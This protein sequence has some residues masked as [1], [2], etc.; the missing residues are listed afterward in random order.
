MPRPN[1]WMNE[2]Y[3]NIKEDNRPYMD[4]YLKDMIKKSFIIFERMKRGQRKVYF[5]GNW[6]K[7]VCSCFP[8]RQSDKIFKKMRVYLDN[9]DYSFTQR[10][11]DNLDGYE[12]IVH[13][14]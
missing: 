11:L 13:R 8:G 12:Y 14:R 2:S 4:P 5:T 3:M 7:D 10:K 9:K 6:Q 1:D